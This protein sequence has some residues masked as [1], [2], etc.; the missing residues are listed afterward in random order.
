M[1]TVLLVTYNHQPYI[2]KA[3]DSIL[4]QK[5]NFKFIIRVLDDCSLDGSVDIIKSYRDRYPS[6]IEFRAV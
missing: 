4:E 2:R 6:I 1:V 3:L 5:T